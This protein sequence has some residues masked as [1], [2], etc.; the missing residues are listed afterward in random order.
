MPMFHTAFHAETP[1]AF[2]R[3]EEP[4][5]TVHAYRP[6]PSQRSFTFDPP[7]KAEIAAKIDA[8]ARGWATPE[9]MV[10]VERYAHWAANREWGEFDDLFSVAL[11]ATWRSLLYAAQKEHEGVYSFDD[12]DSIRRWVMA[13]IRRHMEWKRD[14]NRGQTQK[15][16][17]AP[18]TGRKQD[19]GKFAVYRPTVATVENGDRDTFWQRV[20]EAAHAPQR[21]EVIRRVFIGGENYREIA[22]SK[23]VS[24]QAVEQ[25]VTKSRIYLKAALAEFVA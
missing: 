20:D 16:R 15:A 25:K 19:L 21:I 4:D 12:E 24:F 13:S 5:E 18:R 6:D 14:K 17:H 3:Y 1:A 7:T 8:R 22:R 9:L 23:G 10:H 2:Y 11:L